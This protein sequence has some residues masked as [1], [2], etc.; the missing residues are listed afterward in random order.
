[1]H[2]LALFF[3]PIFGFGFVA[4]FLPSILASLAASAMRDP[5]WL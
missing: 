2:F 4:Y 3:F 1:M 5:S